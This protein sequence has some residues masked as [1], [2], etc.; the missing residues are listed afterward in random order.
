MLL[1]ADCYL[2]LSTRLQTA[3]TQQSFQPYSG[4]FAT[5]VRYPKPNFHNLSILDPSFIFV[6]YVTHNQSYRPNCDYDLNYW[7]T[8]YNGTLHVNIKIMTSRQRWYLLLS[9]FNNLNNL[10]LNCEIPSWSLRFRQF[11]VR[12]V[13]TASINTLVH[14]TVANKWAKVQKYWGISE[15]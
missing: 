1:S 6:R 4:N 5:V 15:I 11:D 12:Q 3:L 14:S 9:Y 13:N 2:A 10:L 7:R 8:Y